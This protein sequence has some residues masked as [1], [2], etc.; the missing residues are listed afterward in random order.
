MNKGR[1][2]TYTTGTYTHICS[3]HRIRG[4][5]AR[6]ILRAEYGTRMCSC[7]FPDVACPRTG[8]LPPPAQGRSLAL[9]I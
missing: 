1:A 9:R 5:T 7:I 4:R 3:T 6:G 2:F 8:T